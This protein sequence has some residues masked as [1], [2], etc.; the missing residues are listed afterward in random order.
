MT[1][2]LSEN[3]HWGFEGLKAALYLGSTEVKSNTAS[4]LPLR[5]RPTRIGSHSS[6]KE[7]DAETGLDFFLARYY[8]PAQG[9]FVSPDD[10][11]NHDSVNPQSLNRYSYVNN[12]PLNYVDPYGYSTHTAYNGDVLAVYNDQ[13][14]G[15][16]RHSGFT[17]YLDWTSQGSPTLSKS[18]KDADQMGFTDRW[19]EFAAHDAKGKGI[20]G[21]HAA[22]ANIR[23][24]Y[25]LDDLFE[26]LNSM[27]VAE[28]MNLAI[29]AYLSRSG[30]PYDI[31]LNPELA[32]SGPF[33]G[34]LLNGKYVTIRSGGNYLAGL[35]AITLKNVFS[36]ISPE[37]AQKLLGAYQ[38][39]GW[40]GLRNTYWTG[41]EYPGTK[42]PYWGE[43]EYSGFYQQMGIKEG[44]KCRK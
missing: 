3:S 34:Y 11:T 2:Q 21:S 44:L 20:D 31:K 23:F 27:F 14:L 22:G 30:G 4:G 18:D 19:D 6:G 35:N 41:K 29:V 7:R 32:L 42:P 8:S 40:K 26:Y 36:Y 39:G 10:G 33:T 17:S 24:E 5:L 37:F 28:H 13:D 16:Y 25:K 43:P 15:V 1:A 12:N 9:R 38:A